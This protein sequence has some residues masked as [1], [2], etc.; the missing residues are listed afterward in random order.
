M[1]HE[2]QRYTKQYWVIISL[3]LQWG[4]WQSTIKSVVKLQLSDSFKQNWNTEVQSNTLCLNYRIFKDDFKFEEY[5]YIMDPRNRTIFT[6][7]RCGS[8]NL[9]IRYN[10]FHGTDERNYRP[11]CQNDI[12]DEYHY[13]LVCPAFDHIRFN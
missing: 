7:F 6:K 12:G 13:L 2:C 10:R 11:L 8:H 9:P 3:E 1:V 5:F 4:Q